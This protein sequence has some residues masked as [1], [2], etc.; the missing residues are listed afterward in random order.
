MRL[1][2][3]FASLVVLVA[4][5]V[6]SQAQEQRATYF[7]YP[8]VPESLTT[9]ADRTSYL[10]EHFWE[11]CNWKSAFSSKQKLAGA[12]A[13]YASFI[14]YANAETVHASI[15]SLLK[16]LEK[17][18]AG[19]LAIAE[20]AEGQ[21]Y[22]DT[23]AIECDECYYPFAKAVADNGKLSKTDKARFVYQAEIL[24]ASQVGMDAPD[25]TYTTPDGQTG[26]LSDAPAG[27]Y[28]LLF[29]NDPDCTDCEL[30]RVRLQAD[31]SL[32]D[33]IDR[34]VLKVVS[35]YPGEPDDAWKEA[36]KTYSSRWTV[37]A[38]PDVD[39]VY[40]M[41]RSPTIYYLNGQHKILSKSFDIDNLLV[42]FKQVNDKMKVKRKE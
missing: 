39:N 12:F 23:A 40:D 33:L 14:P 16:G 26:K 15:A 29:F 25:F 13:D 22:A 17:N 6:N 34:G 31:Y 37:G 42:A 10:V 30:A 4:T 36:A 41:R 8:T 24:G 27:A 5:V 21:F 7:P 2:H 18:P 19:L 28:V 35:V 38:S 11:H 20:M 1:K 3:I 32:N 9:L